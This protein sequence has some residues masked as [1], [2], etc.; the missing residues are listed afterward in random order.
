MSSRLTT[1]E[2]AEV[3]GISPQKARRAFSRALAGLQWRGARLVVGP[4]AGRGGLAGQSY[5][6]RVDSLPADLQQRL[7]Q[8]FAIVE[9]P[10]FQAA[11]DLSSKKHKW[12][13]LVLMPA[14]M[15]PARSAERRTAIEAIAAQRHIDWN[16]QAR[17]LSIRTIE[18][19]IAAHDK[20]GA[21][22]FVRHSR[23]DKG[24]SLVAISKAWDFAVTID[25]VLRPQIAEQIRK[26]VRGLL[27]KDTSRS[28]VTTLATAKLRELTIAAGM[29]E[30][31]EL[32]AD[33]FAL[34]RRFIDLEKRIRNVAI[35]D[36]NRKLYEDN[37]PR[38]MRTAA[39][40]APQQLVV[41]D[42]HHIDIVMRRPDGTEAWP[43]AIAWLD[44]A[45][46]RIWIDL[47]LLEKGEGIRNSHVIASFIKMVTAW[48]MPQAVYLDNGSEY[49]WADFVDDALKL[50]AHIDYNFE[51]RN[52]QVVRAKPYNAAAKSI[53]NKFRVL[54]QT[55]FRTLPGWA[56]GDRTNQRTHQV[57]K[58]TEPFPGTIEDLARAIG[59][60]LAL[61]HI[62]AQ[63]GTL[64]GRSP[65]QAFDAAVRSG[66]QRVAIDPRE[67]A[68]VFSTEETRIPRQGYISFAG[69][70]WTCRELQRFQGDRVIVHAPKF[71]QYSELPLR[72]PANRKL[73]GSA[74]RA[75]RYGILDPA[76]AREA[77]EMERAGRAGIRE[78]RA[79]VPD[80]DPNAEIAA[81][82]S[83]AAPALLAPIIG[84]IGIS[85]ERAEM[86]RG[87]AE[88]PAAR[89]DRQQ[90]EAAKVE[91]AENDRIK[92]FARKLLPEKSR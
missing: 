20:V 13:S 40:Y 50:V 16:N 47:V 15:P 78:L 90:D 79:D 67:L 66:W 91:A 19:W 58:S 12:F 51:D 80:I 42:V 54:E 27:I 70:K 22:A 71:D 76:G 81:L 34:P 69:D 85:D 53:E 60:C 33:V 26:Y 68:T 59:N 21:A 36:R 28:V 29:E 14:L 86:A 41:G 7:K 43:K 49:R 92:K 35:F 52:S 18:R 62:T 87:M 44:L 56:G 82:V 3:A 77:A 46:N 6:V 23:R 31:R 24:A 89:R 11:D 88:T 1:T 17:K 73:I 38:L 75:T 55:Y 39:G 74:T 84:T 57:G 30:A 45:T 10:M 64:K 8:H 83:S 9:R 5:T 61:Y 63:A 2:F 48:G 25:P 32:P 4:V 37:R 72:D 65:Q